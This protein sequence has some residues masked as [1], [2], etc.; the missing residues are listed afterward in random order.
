MTRIYILLIIF[1]LLI[2]ASMFSQ[3]NSQDGF[4]AE[5]NSYRLA[6][7]KKPLVR[8]IDLESQSNARA[9]RLEEGLDNWS[10]GAFREM[11]KTKVTNNIE[12]GE[13]LGK[14]YDNFQD[15]MVAWDNS[16]TH[17]S[18]MLGNWC[19][20]GIGKYGT[21]WVQHFKIDNNRGCF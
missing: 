11:V 16:P 3:N 7:G 14:G 12:L 15:A 18:V 19:E 8:N 2:I 17:K 10:H 9:Y 20:A 4:Y 13:N 6:H 1:I 21:Y 5:L